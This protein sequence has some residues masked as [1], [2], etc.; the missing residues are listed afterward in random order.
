MSEFRLRRVAIDDAALLLSWRNHPEVKR[1][2]FSQN[3]ITLEGHIAWLSN[4]LNDK[5]KVLLVYEEDFV[6]KGFVSFIRSSTSP[7]V[8]D[9]GFYTAPDAE[10]GTGTRLGT[11]VLAYAFDQCG[12][13]KICGQVLEFNQRSIRFHEKLGFKLEGVLSEQYLQGGKHIAIH[14]FGMLASQWNNK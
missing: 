8:V 11:A 4:A 7:S 9:W 13:H 3:E 10:K 1:Y 5:N 2:M 6:P 14:C 12:F